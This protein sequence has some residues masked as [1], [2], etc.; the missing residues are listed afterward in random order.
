MNQSSEVGAIPAHNLTAAGTANV[1]VQ[2]RKLRA[3]TWT[4]ALRNAFLDHLATSSNVTH[5]ARSVG[6]HP[7][8]AHQLRRR[9]PAFAE[10]WAEA[11]EQ[12]YA[13]IE[14]MLLARAIGQEADPL[15][16]GDP[17]A[18]PFDPAMA[19]QVLMT[20]KGMTAPGRTRVGPATRQVS[21]EQ[22]EQSLRKKLD[23]LAKRLKA[24]F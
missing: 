4:K 21:I 8:S 24:D 23:A 9:D 12:G 14:A 20:R 16:S 7:V 22:V 19:L 6:K 2:V 1:K 18:V 11:L 15:R 17:D 13:H 3:G 5:A 10:A